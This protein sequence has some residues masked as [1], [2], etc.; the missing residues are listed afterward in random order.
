M[1]VAHD[2][3]GRPLASPARLYQRLYFS[4]YESTLPLYRGQ[5]ALFGSASVMPAKVAWDYTYYW[6]VLC[7]LFFQRRLGDASLFAELGPELMAAQQLNERMQALLR[8]WHAVADRPN[9]AG[10]LD[11]CRVPWLVELNRG[12][13]DTLD[14]DGVRARLRGNLALLNEVAGAIGAMAARD[15]VPLDGLPTCTGP[16]PGLFDFAPAGKMASMA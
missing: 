7:Q 4:F 5:Y 8:R 1:L 15:G 12:L 2:R 11:Q 3:A 16:A 14:D 13:R 10:L 9:P 6:G